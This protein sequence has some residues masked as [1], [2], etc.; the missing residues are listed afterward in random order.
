MKRTPL[1]RKTR[2]TRKTPLAKRSKTNSRRRNYQDHLH[3]KEWRALKKKVMERDGCSCR[4]CGAETDLSVHHLHYES[5]RHEDGTELVTLCAS[6]H[7]WADM[8]RVFGDRQ[9][10]PG[11]IPVNNRSQ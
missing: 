3:S 8:E 4:K 6:C 2:L 9:D 5:F 11:M 10:F 7:V 1:K